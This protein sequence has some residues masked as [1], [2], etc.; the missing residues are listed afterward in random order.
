MIC[1]E[2]RHLALAVI[3]L[4]ALVL[5]LA[6]LQYAGVFYESD[7]FYYFSILSQAHGLALPA[8]SAFD[9]M[10]PAESLGLY[11]GPLALHLIGLPMY[12]AV[13]L[14]APLARPAPPGR[15]RRSTTDSPVRPWPS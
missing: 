13:A 7:V 15:S 4:L 14:A 2:K 9:L 1:V 10:P 12:W 3:V 8:L 11:A 5:R 6:S